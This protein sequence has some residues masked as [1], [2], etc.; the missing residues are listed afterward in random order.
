MNDASEKMLHDL[1][2]VG[3]SAGTTTADRGKDAGNRSTLVV[4][5]EQDNCR[6]HLV[7]LIY[8]FNAT[9]LMRTIG[10]V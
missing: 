10:N 3:G 1:G 7:D 4:P 5:D 6:I 8:L 2:R 9:F